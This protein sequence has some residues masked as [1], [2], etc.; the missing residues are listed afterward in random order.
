MVK[1]ILIITGIIIVSFALYV[2]YI[3]ATTRNHSPQQE[4]EFNGPGDLKINIVYCRP[5]KKD[6]DIFGSGLHDYLVPYN[7]PW[8]TGANE[9]T[10]IEFNQDVKLNGSTLEKGQYSIYT[11]PGENEWI[12]AINSKTDYWGAQVG[13]GSPFDESLDVLRTTVPS[14]KQDPP[15]EQ[16]TI[17]FEEKGDHV[18]WSMAW[19]NVRIVVPVEAL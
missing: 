17:R 14:M 5:Y 1:K 10:E 7:V 19:D 9:A 16:F 6:R 2:L 13:G 4:I 12:V 15:D 3:L 11:I 8:R 18:E